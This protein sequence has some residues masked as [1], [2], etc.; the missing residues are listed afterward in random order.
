MLYDYHTAY[1]HSHI[2]LQYSLL[3]L[4]YTTTIQPTTTPIYNYYTYLSYIQLPYS[5]L[6]LLY[7]TTT[8]IYTT[9]IEPTPALA[10]VS[11]HHLLPLLY[12]TLICTTIIQP[13]TCPISNY[14]ALQRLYRRTM[15]SLHLHEWPHHSKNTCIDV[16]MCV[17]AR[18][19]TWSKK[20]AEVVQVSSR[21]LAVTHH[22]WC[23]R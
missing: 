1:N 8:Y 20:K 19:F 23:K 16:Y 22:L 7:T 21:H 9:T 12:T 4:L 18:V 15:P 6:P 14:H 17:C 10:P 5:L 3:P 11:N 13:T 2:Q